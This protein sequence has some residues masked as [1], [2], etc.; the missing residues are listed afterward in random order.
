M[1][2]GEVVVNA[3][4][5]TNKRAPRDCDALLLRLSGSPSNLRR[6]AVIRQT[7]RLSISQLVCL[8]DTSEIRGF[9]C[10]F[11]EDAFDFDHEHVMEITEASVPGPRR[12]GKQDRRD[13]NKA[14][15]DSRHKAL[16]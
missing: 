13:G 5:C 15:I 3:G 2:P 4:Q 8:L 14:E 11:W 6:P 1:R 10:V 7:I 12:L 9:Y 16:G